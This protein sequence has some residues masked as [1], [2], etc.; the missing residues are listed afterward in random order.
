MYSAVTVTGEDAADFLQGQLTQDLGAVTSGH[1]PLSAWCSPRGRVVA[2]MRVALQPGGY[3][4]LLPA[5]MTAT[6][7][8]GLARYRLRSR[9]E[10]AEAPADFRVLAVADS[11]DFEL[12]DA[13]GLLP[14][15]R[16][17][18]SVTK[19][20]VVVVCPDAGRAFVEVFAAG[21]ALAAAGLE[22]T[23]PLSAADWR[24]ARIAA[25]IVDIVPATSEHYTPHMLNLD[26][27][28]AVSF[29]KGCYTGQEVIA[30]TE[31]RGRARRRL[32]RYTAS[33]PVTAGDAV[34]L[35]GTGVGNVVAAGATQ[36]LA[37]LPVDL[38]DKAL[39]TGTARLTPAS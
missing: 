6:V 12:L 9:A 2:V 26:R 34:L 5:D 23:A 21:D 37:I 30:R 31:H 24:D 15:A 38:H 18:A 32:A 13:R 27:L 29:D 1:S 7:A 14:P 3:I 17:D 28:G 25:G 33:A 20:G 19:D 8:A 10:I 16:R 39:E 22:F 4:L 11:A 35:E 36:V